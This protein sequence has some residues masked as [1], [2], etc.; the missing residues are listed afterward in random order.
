MKYTVKNATQTGKVDAKFGTEYLVNFNEDDRVV[1]MSRQKPVEVGQEENG[2]IV[3]SKYGAYFKKDPYVQQPSGG[4]VNPTK[5]EWTPIKKDNSDGQ[6]QGMCLNNAANFVNNHLGLEVDPK[7]WAET[8]HSFATALY[9]LGDLKEEVKTAPVVT[10]EAQSV[11][12][13]IGGEPISP[14]AV[15]SNK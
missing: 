8:V 15:P 13:L 4:V 14:K 1:K 2:T 9:N 6:R 10:E 7:V 3:D 11:M 12:D 5:K